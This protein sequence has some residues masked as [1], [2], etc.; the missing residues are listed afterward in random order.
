MFGF[1]TEQWLGFIRHVLTGLGGML[2]AAGWI[3]ADT[4]TQL[5][6]GAMTVVGF[7]WSWFTKRGA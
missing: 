1:T 6:G 2:V 5:V 4:A 7:F 3:D